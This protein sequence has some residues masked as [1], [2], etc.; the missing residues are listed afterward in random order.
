MQVRRAPRLALLVALFTLALASTTSAQTAVTPGASRIYATIYSVGVEWD[1]AGDTNHS[2]TAV[3]NYRVLGTHSWSSALPLVRVDFSGANMLAGSILFLTPG[4]QYEVRVDLSDSDGGGEIRVLTVTTRALPMLPTNGRTW[5]V[6]PG[7]G[8]GDGSAGSPFRGIA[9]AQ[10]VAQPG[11][12]VLVHGGDYGGRIRLDRSG[13]PGRYIAWRAYGDGEVRFAGIDIAASHIWLEGITVR[14]Q[15][16]AT[17]SIAAPDDVVVRRCFFYN[18]HYSIY[19]QQGGTNWY[20][21]DNTI[22]GDTPYATESFDGEGIELNQSAGGHTVAH[23]SITNVADGISYPT[24]NVDIFGNDIFDTSDDGIEADNGRA[25]VRIWGNR[26]HNAVHNGI[27]FQPQSSGPWYI[28]RNQIVGNV[29]GAFKFRTTDRFALLHNT[30]VNWGNAWPGDAMIC[31]NEDHLMRAM[32]RNNLWI[33]VNGGQIWGFDGF[34]KDWRTDLDYDGF[35]W[36]AASNPFTYGGVV[37]GD[38]Q[39]FASASGLEPAG[40]RVSKACFATFDVPTPP[41]S[42]VPPQTMTLVPECNAIDAGTVLPDIDDGFAGAAPDLGAYE[43]GWPVPTYGP[44]S[45]PSARLHLSV[46]RITAGAEATLSWTTTD[47]ATVSIDALGTVAGGGVT[48]VTPSETS[49]Y[50]LTAIN[51]Y[52]VTTATV[53]LVVDAAPPALSVPNAPT[54]LSATAV[55]S[56]RIHLAW[57]DTSSNEDGFNIE[58]SVDGGQFVQVRTVTAGVTVVDVLNLSPSRTYSYR[59]SAFNAAGSSAPSQIATAVTPQAPLGAPTALTVVVVSKSALR[60]SWQDNSSAESGFRIERSTNNKTYSVVTTTS[61]GA[62]TFVDSALRSGQTYYY[63]VS[64]INATG[65]SSPA[66]VSGTTPKK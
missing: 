31:C 11:D 8:Q 13:N 66:A 4:T 1:L 44:R 40:S 42:P 46:S 62:T 43:S 23:N 19:L 9:A 18:N 39:S 47:A 29:E 5:H 32:S 37:Y 60:L 22:V 28:V 20:I 14:N 6:A 41:P 12:V 64:A 3:V 16:Y 51:Q 49:T 33:S 24:T 53:T 38:L 54:L 30:I 34:I 35:D 55:T 65:A 17:F 63:K 27:S 58:Q 59:V 48:V 21:A 10:A 57:T 52:G 50:T 61:P 15:A 26:I 7:V 56:D 2:A 25:N 36:G 45:A